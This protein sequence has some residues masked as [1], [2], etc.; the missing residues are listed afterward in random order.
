MVVAVSAEGWMKSIFIAPIL[1]LAW[2]CPAFAQADLAAIC[3][4]G[5]ASP[6]DKARPAGIAGVTL[7]EIDPKV[8]IPA[9]TAAA[10]ATPAQARILYQLGRA[11]YVAKDYESARA[12][13]AKADELGYALATNNLAALYL[14]GE[15]VSLDSSRAIYLFEK[16]AKGGVTI[17]MITLGDFYSKGRHV[18]KD[19][20]QARHW[21]EKAAAGGEVQAMFALGVLYGV[22]YGVPKNYSKALHW[23][24]KAAAGGHAIAMNNIGVLYY[25]GHGVRRDKPEALRWLRK[26]AAGGYAPA[27]EYLKKVDRYEAARRRTYSDDERRPSFYVRPGLPGG[28][29]IPLAGGTTHMCN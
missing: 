7:N 3:D 29:C 23:Y 8:A 26:S 16:A 2:A 5:A 14:Y 20:T 17:A 25:K 27:A 10:K 22:G 1:A 21:Y 19:W 28:S 15:G 18:G 4:Q 6:L 13:Y 11:H 9:C 12:Q 24:E